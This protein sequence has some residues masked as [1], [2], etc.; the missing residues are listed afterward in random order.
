MWQ[1]DAASQEGL[2]MFSIKQKISPISPSH[3]AWKNGFQGLSSQQPGIFLPSSHDVYQLTKSSLPCSTRFK[4]PSP[5][6]LFRG[7]FED[8]HLLLYR[9]LCQNFLRVHSFLGYKESHMSNIFSG[10]HLYTE[11]K[12]LH[13]YIFMNRWAESA[14]WGSFTSSVYLIGSYIIRCFFESVSVISIL[15]LH[16]NMR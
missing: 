11:I 13:G 14:L 9:A 12:S 16:T 7:V 2:E 5:F 3:R 1:T 8:H 10:N 15:S 6:W 4:P